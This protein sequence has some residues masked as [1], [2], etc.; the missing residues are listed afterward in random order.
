MIK[1]QAIKFP[2]VLL[3]LTLLI[4]ALTSCKTRKITDTK[5]LAKNNALK[6]IIDLHHSKDFKF[7]TLQSRLKVTYDDGQKS[8]SPSAS[9]RIEKDKQIWLSVKFLG[10]TMAK[11]YITPQR[12]SFYEK[13]TKTYYDGNFEALSNFLG[14]DV[15]FDKTQN[16]LLGQSILELENQIY[17]INNELDN[18]ILITPKKQDPLYEILLGLY[19]SSHKVSQLQ[20]TQEEKSNAIKVTYPEY[21]K[22]AEQDFPKNINITTKSEQ[23]SKRI[24]IDYKATTVNTPLTFPYKIPNGYTAFTLK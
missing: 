14:T 23:E 4:L 17:N 6:E 5:G 16:L 19:N 24:N 20:I 7:S 18:Q 1:F 9:L 11:A 21:Q 2:K 10:I 15:N 12:V 8:I 13:L 22:I 3:V